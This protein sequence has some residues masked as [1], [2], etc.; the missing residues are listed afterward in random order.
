MFAAKTGAQLIA[1]DIETP[2]EH[3]TLRGVASAKGSSPAHSA[4]FP[5]A[6]RGE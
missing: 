2:A 6:G 4:P 5:G 1:E 3:D